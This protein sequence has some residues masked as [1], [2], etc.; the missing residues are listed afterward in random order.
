MAEE[1]STLFKGKEIKL[2]EIFQLFHQLFNI[3]II[4]FQ[5]NINIL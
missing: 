2:C 3:F 4:F 5:L 1:I